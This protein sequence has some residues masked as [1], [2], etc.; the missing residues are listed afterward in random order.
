MQSSILPQELF[1][2]IAEISAKVAIDTFKAEMQKEAK[3]KEKRADKG[4]LVRDILKTYRA[5]KSSL[6]E[7]IVLT[8]EEEVEHRWRFLEDLMGCSSV[9][10]SR[11]EAEILDFEKKRKKDAYIVRE[12]DK[13]MK[14]YKK[15]CDNS[16]SEEEKRRYIELHDM[17]IKEEEV[18]ALELA[19]R[20]CISEK[21]VYKD[22]GIASRQLADYLI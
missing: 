18:T 21:T 17:Y 14:M 16:S 13:A 9:V 7:E 12:I 10:I 8:K 22:I 1:N 4:R 2:V 3:K 6:E 5:K 19:E 15:K 20:F 11:T